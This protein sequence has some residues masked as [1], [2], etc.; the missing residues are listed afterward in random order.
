MRVYC[1]QRAATKA[2]ITLSEARPEHGHEDEREQD[3][4][5]RENDVD[6]T[7]DHVA[8]QPPK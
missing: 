5:D 4:G 3:E 7:H 2:M 8:T 6:E 1:T